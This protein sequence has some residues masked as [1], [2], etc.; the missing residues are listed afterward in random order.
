[1]GFIIWMCTGE[2]RKNKLLYSSK[3]RAVELFVLNLG[4]SSCM[5]LNYSAS[6][7]NLVERRTRGWPPDRQTDTGG[8]KK[9]KEARLVCV[10]N[11]QVVHN[12]LRVQCDRKWR[13]SALL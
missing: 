12:A 4:S 5:A 7:F 1:M 6:M 2:S 10:C 8:K 9:K 3:V 13:G 11:T